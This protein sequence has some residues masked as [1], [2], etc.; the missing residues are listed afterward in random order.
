MPVAQPADKGQDLCNGFIDLWQD[1]GVVN[2]AV[3]L[4]T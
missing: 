2:F 4:A 1:F 3:I